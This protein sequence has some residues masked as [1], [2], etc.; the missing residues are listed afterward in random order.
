MIDPQ[1]KL[2][3]KWANKKAIALSG[4]NTQ[5]KSFYMTCFLCFDIK[6]I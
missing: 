2:N 3:K 5:E 4:L 6:S 1:Y